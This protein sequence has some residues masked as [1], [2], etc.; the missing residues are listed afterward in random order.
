MQILYQSV[1]IGHHV[2]A[3]LDILAIHFLNSPLELPDGGVLVAPDR[4]KVSVEEDLVG[5]PRA[6]DLTDKLAAL[7]LEFN[8]RAVIVTALGHDYFHGVRC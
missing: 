7:D 8:I 6:V 5:L 3:E 2:P 1:L 4:D